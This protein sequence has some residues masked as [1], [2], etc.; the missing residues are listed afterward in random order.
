MLETLYEKVKLYLTSKSEWFKRLRWR[1]EEPEN[2]PNSG[3]PSTAFHL[4]IIV[5]VHKPVSTGDQT[6]LK[7]MQIRQGLM[8]Q[9]FTDFGRRKMFTQFVLYSLMDKKNKHSLTTSEESFISYFHT[10]LQL[11][12][13]LGSFRMILKQNIRAWTDE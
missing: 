4:E 12:M 6:N 5:K 2:D 13:R 8:H 7:L 3:W 11:V 1:C 9:I 10:N